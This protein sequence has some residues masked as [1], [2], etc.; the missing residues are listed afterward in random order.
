VA[1]S[2]DT[3]ALDRELDAA[4]KADT[5]SVL[6]PLVG[7]LSALPGAEPSGKNVPV[8]ALL[9]A[10]A[11]VEIALAEIGAAA[12]PSADTGATQ[13][14]VEVPKH[15]AA[16]ETLASR[17]LELDPQNS[18]AMVAEADAARLRGRPAREAESWLKKAL[19]KDRRDR[20]AAL[21]QALLLRRDKRLREARALLEE[22]AK[23]AEDDVR[24]AY[25]LAEIDVTEAKFNDARPRLDAILKQQPQHV[26]A[27]A[28]AELI[29][30]RA[31][32]SEPPVDQTDPMPPEVT[33]SRPSVVSKGSHATGGGGSAANG[34]DSYDRLLARADR[35]AQGGN[36]RVAIPTYERALDHN[37]AGVG[38]LTG[39]GYCY[40][41]ARDYG[42]A[43]AK[44]RAALGISP[45][46]QTAILGMAET[47]QRDG[48]TAHAI[49]MYK[50]FLSEYPDTPRASVVRR[51]IERLSGNT[52]QRGHSP[53]SQPAADEPP[54]ADEP[55]PAD[56][57]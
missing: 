24:P 30:S 13:R 56:E 47:Y 35:L 52:P 45:R 54:P 10:R 18:A 42:R 19:V 6:E 53:D 50:R 57:P 46:Y 39:L 36:C 14:R 8:P 43:F 17:A 32:T 49:E 38:A 40:L 15:L 3:V 25:H 41:D 9:A 4:I 51:Q 7:R 33:N 48:D 27:L 22:L 16:A 37:P 23:R 1:P 12:A 34:E 21:S 55:G 28:L 2:A 29:A 20:E 5:A 44:F 31:G 26:G 11:R